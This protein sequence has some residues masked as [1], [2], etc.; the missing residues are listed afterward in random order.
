LFYFLVTALPVCAVLSF[1]SMSKGSE[2]SVH[3]FRQ[4]LEIFWKKITRI[5]YQI[6]HLLGI[7]I[8]PNSPDLDPTK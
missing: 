6:Y 8:D 4:P 1:S 7:D 3:Y 2:F 5:V